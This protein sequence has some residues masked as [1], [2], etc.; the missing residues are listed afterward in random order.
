MVNNEK[1]IRNFVSLSLWL[2]PIAALL[3][4]VTMFYFGWQLTACIA[5]GVTL[6]C[7]IWWIF[8]PIP[9]PATSLIP[10]GVFPL[11][12]VLNGEQVAQAYGSPLILLLMGGAMLSKAMEKSGA[13]RRVALG[14]VKA[15]GSNSYRQLV[16]GFMAASALLSMW[17]SNTATT[18]MLLPVALA[19][20]EKAKNPRLAIPLLLGIAYSASIGGLGTPIGTTPNVIFINVYKE[21]TGIEPTFFQWMRWA[22][23][24][25]L[26]LLP[27]AAWWLTRQLKGG[28]AIDIPHLGKWRSEEKRV[29]TIF[30][31]T[32][33]AWMTLK[34]PWGG[35]SQWFKVPNANYAAVA[36]TAV[37][38][39]FVCPSGN[40]RERLLDWQTASSI[41]WGVLLLFAGGIAIAKAFVNT[42]ISESLGNLLAGVTSM[43]KFLV[44]LCLCVGVTFLTEI[45]SNTATTALLMPILA[46]AALGANMDPATLMIPAALSAS[47]AF[48]LPVA[49]APN[50]IVFGTGKFT[51][52]QMVRIGVGINLM[53]ALAVSLV[54]YFLV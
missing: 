37:V 46:A 8:E 47:C 48:M 38:V 19:V 2:A 24:A 13:H 21:N 34:D 7:A 45:T 29:L 39:L 44:I 52:Q 33:L 43:P 35:W 1:N 20:L 14:M 16:W 54:I 53:G 26:V 31:L 17:I 51:V 30:A 42:G 25:V 50:A 40:K 11:L 4:A 3:L 49:T 41:Q 22:L 27:I 23:P 6:V 18:L 36:L 32:A 15:F 12:G 5:G 28:E 10:I 9:I